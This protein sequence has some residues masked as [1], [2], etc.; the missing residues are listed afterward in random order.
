MR[1]RELGAFL[2]IL[3][4][5]LA[6]HIQ[7]QGNLL[8]ANTGVLSPSASFLGRHYIERI[9]YALAG[10]GDVNGDGFDDFL[11]GTFH[12]AVMGSDAGAA[13]LFLGQSRLPWGLNTS[14]DSANARLLGQIAYDAAGYS[15][16]C[17]GDLNGDGFDDMIIGAPAGNDKV[18]W[19]SGRV[20]IV[21]GKKKADWGRYFQLY[22]SSNLIY[23]G[24][25]NQDLAGLSV[26]YI[27]D[28]NLDG[29]D[30][31]IVGAP[32]KDGKFVDEGKVYLILG[33]A[34]YSKRIDFLSY[35]TA[36]F[37]Y[38]RDG[39]EIGYS[40]AGIGDVNA[41]GIPDFAIGALSASRVFVIFGRKNVNWGAN[42][43]LD[44][45]DLILYG[46]HQ[47][48]SEGVGWKIAG[49]GDLNGDRID[50]MFIPAIHDDDGG[51]HAGKVYVLLGKKGGWSNQTI[52]LN[53]GADA[54]FQGE[55]P[56]DQAGWGVAIAGDVDDDGFDDFLIGTYKDDQG[57]VDGKAYL[58]K[59]KATGWKRNVPLATIPDYCERAAEGVGFA[60]AS[61][62]DF[63]HDGI[64]DFLIAAPFNNEVQK[65]TGEVYLFASQQVPYTIAGNVTYLQSQKP[66][67]GTILSADPAYLDTTDQQGNYQMPV[68]GKKDY[69]VHI[70]KNKGE[71]IGSAITSYDAALI[72]RM[73]VNLDVP[74]A[75]NKAAADAN[76][77]SRVNMYDAAIALR[78]AVQLPPLMDSHAGEW[79]FNPTSMFYDSIIADQS[80]QNYQGYIIC[81]VDA[82]YHSPG[83]GGLKIASADNDITSY[84][85]QPGAEIF[86]PIA[87]KSE[88][89]MLSFDLD[90]SY[91]QQALEFL[92]IETTALTNN[93]QLAYNAK[94]EDRLLIG[95]YAPDPI[96]A[97]GTLLFIVFKAKAA[98][99]G[100]TEI[101]LT[102]FLIDN[103]PAP[104]A[105]VKIAIG[106]QTQMPDQ[107][108]LLQNFPNPFN[109]ST[110]IPYDVS[111]RGHIKVVIYNTLGAEI[112]TLLDAEVSPGGYV[113]IWDGKDE[114]G[115]SVASGVYLCQASLASDA[116][117]IKLVY[118]K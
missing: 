93:F 2:V 104:L 86:L 43:N 44:E 49:G 77:D 18:P 30:D 68:R 47:W 97:A 5:S 71:H 99:S 50:D 91:D 87:I 39:A 100:K 95:A 117:N 21:F 41:D 102:N 1:I 83:L 114:F 107:F 52:A 82:N 101:H 56:G 14:V 92:S 69:T 78:Y 27:G 80:N 54:S 42:F 105:T 20:Y 57:P 35:A 70:K 55:L 110:A 106:D 46:K 16:A 13:Y 53:D 60:C 19:V 15:V 96:D 85:T 11:I 94:L 81:D 75:S 90:F 45:A 59:G 61:A 65:W 28:V 62:G 89:Q 29:Y 63:D 17:N 40:V 98:A 72:A 51:F 116:Q 33:K 66:I 76:S 34:T 113:L 73:A 10:A 103:T 8:K 111:Q 7:A 26:A 9:G 38:D 58:I 115:K 24:E 48:V 74:N 32:F 64:D 88:K 67:P 12:N 31:F 23:E 108:R 25:G 22:D 79:V 118:M 109:Q 6:S 37:R 3:L 84:E 112:K 4:L 36:G